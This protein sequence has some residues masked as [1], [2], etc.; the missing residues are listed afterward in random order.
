VRDFADATDA[1][2]RAVALSPEWL[3][4][5]FSDD[6]RRMASIFVPRA[7]HDGLTFLTDQYFANRFE[8]VLNDRARI[9]ALAQEAAQGPLHF[10]FHTAFCGSTLLVKALTVEG[11]V[12]GLKEPV[13]LNDLALRNSGQTDDELLLTLR[14]LA[15]PFDDGGAVIVKAANVANRLL[16]PTLRLAPT[17]R[18]ILMYSDL[19]SMLAAIAK[20]GLE[21]RI[22]VRQLFPALSKWAPLGKVLGAINALEL[23]D[24]QLAALTWLMQ[25]HHFQE[26]AATFGEERVMLL[27]AAEFLGRPRQTL[28]AVSDFLELGLD[29]AMI[30]SIAGGP[31]FRSHS[32]NIG[33]SYDIEQRNRDIAAAQQSHE[34]EI[35]AAMAWLQHVTARAPGPFAGMLGAW[36]REAMVR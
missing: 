36:I 24:L 22:W 18:A 10:I 32:K 8:V 33:A 9:D 35:K 2:C 27:D 5:S 17:S 4:H 29:A 34:P 16:D 21:R 11:R 13:I 25:V 28:A 23:A 7:G 31:V 20:Q 26:I 19:S 14:L 6:G 3:P 15:R 30:D 1:A 12:M